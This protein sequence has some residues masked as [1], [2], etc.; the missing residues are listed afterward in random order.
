MSSATPATAAHRD[1]GGDLAP[2]HIHPSRPPRD[3][4]GD[5]ALTCGVVALVFVFVP[6]IADLIT[7]PAA[8]AAILLALTNLIREHRNLSAHSNRALIGGLLGAVA[9]LI[10]LMVFAA[11]GTFT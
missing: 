4:I 2:H 6:I 8:I 10:T 9:A 3:R 7:P 11:T 5:A 1:V